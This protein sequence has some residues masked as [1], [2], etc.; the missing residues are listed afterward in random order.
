MAADGGS[1]WDRWDAI[2]RLL[3]LALDL[4][5]AERREAIH[6]AADG[7]TALESAVIRLLHRLETDQRLSAPS[8]QLVHD[9]FA[10]EDPETVQPGDEIGRF[11]ILS[12]LGRGGMATVYRAERA[13]GT[14]QQQVALKLLRRGLD[15]DDLIRRF[16]AERQ[17]LS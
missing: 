8:G 17:I 7:D 9:A 4:P 10:E 14:Y 2:D 12:R 1:I 13:D 15:T 6:R 11:R 3:E 16:V 5:E